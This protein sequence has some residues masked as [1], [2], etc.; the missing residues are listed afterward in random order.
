MIMMINFPNM[1]SQRQFR[2]ATAGLT[3]IETIVAIAVLA[4]AI[5]GPLHLAVKSLNAT[6]DATSEMAA[7]QLAVEA[8]EVV[9]NLRDN[10]SADGSVAGTEWMNNILPK[11][12]AGCI[13]DVAQY[14]TAGSV[15]SS[16]VLIACVGSCVSDANAK[17]YKHATTGFFRS[18]SGLGAGWSATPYRRW[19]TVIDRSSGVTKEVEVVA[20]ATYLSVGGQTKTVSVSER[21]LNWFPAITDPDADRFPEYH[22]E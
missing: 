1:R 19:V 2:S 16:N 22:E 3:L 20:H 21:L 5:A 4:L 12:A 14:N 15:W 9:R 8:I 17:V 7:T 6:H 13:V 18:A 10:N 11:C